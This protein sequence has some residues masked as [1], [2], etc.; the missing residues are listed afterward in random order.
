[1][2]EGSCSRAKNSVM[3]SVVVTWAGGCYK[4][5]HGKEAGLRLSCDAVNVERSR[6]NAVARLGYNILC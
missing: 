1:M 6:V 2:I 3:L 4:L 5:L